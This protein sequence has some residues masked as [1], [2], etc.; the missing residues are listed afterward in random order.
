M[1][2]IAAA[3]EDDLLH[4]LLDRAARDQLSDLRRGGDVVALLLALFRR[5]AR[6]CGSDR[7]A[8]RV[9]DQLRIDMLARAVHREPGTSTARLRDAIAHAPGAPIEQFLQVGHDATFPYFFLPSL[10]R[11]RSL[12]YLTPLPLYGSGGR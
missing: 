8:L 9:V 4:A 10:R 1:I 6:A 11:M 2:K 12:A 5:F 7:A 3:V